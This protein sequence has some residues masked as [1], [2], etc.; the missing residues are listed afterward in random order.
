MAWCIL[1]FR[2]NAQL[3]KQRGLQRMATFLISFG[4]IF[5]GSYLIVWG[6]E[7]SSTMSSV[8]IVLLNAITPALVVKISSLESHS[9]ESSYS[10]SLYLKITAIRWANTAIITRTITPFTDLIRSGEYLLES[11]RVLLTAEILQ[12]PILEL[13]DFSGNIKK[14]YSAPRAPDQR[15]MYLCFLSDSYDIGERYTDISKVLFL[16]SIYCTLMPA[17]FFYASII[18]VVYYWMDKYLILNVWR[19]AP[20]INEDISIV[21]IYTFVLNIIV[22][23]IVAAFTIAQFPYDDACPVNGEEQVPLDY[24]NATILETFNGEKVETSVDGESVAYKFCNQNLLGSNIGI[25]PFHSLL[26]GQEWMST[27]QANLDKALGW[28]GMIVYV[29]VVVA[30][31]YRLTTTI[32]L[33]YFTVEKVSTSHEQNSLS[34]L[35]YLKTFLSP[36]LIP[37]I[38]SK[39][40]NVDSDKGFSEVDE[41]Y[42]YVPQVKIS[43][44]L[45][46]KLLCQVDEDCYDLV[47]WNDPNKKGFDDHN[48]MND[49]EDRGVNTFSVVRKWSP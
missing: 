21:S 32:V 37:L 15:R 13:L 35:K 14:H 38:K 27:S 45:Y 40:F 4:I 29:A 18:F 41:I 24:M 34:R 26:H 9:N 22:Y 16:T 20:R 47:G 33:P 28:V 36:Q 17:A 42:G 44:S 3:L 10:A 31:I 11:I 1:S 39:T 2:T 46:P 8:V 12:R 43:G 30:I 49:V 23:V 7:H 6:N 25:F 5:G 48:L 19:Q